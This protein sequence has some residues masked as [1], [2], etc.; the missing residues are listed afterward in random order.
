MPWIADSL[1]FVVI[2]L[3]CCV[4]RFYVHFSWGGLNW[5]LKPRCPKSMNIWFGA[6]YQRGNV[7]YMM[8]SCLSLSMYC[9]S[10]RKPPL[11]CIVLIFYGSSLLLWSLYFVY[12]LQWTTIMWFSYFR[13]K[14][15]LESGHFLSVINI[16]MQL[17]KVSLLILKKLF[18][19]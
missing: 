18:N 3:V 7:I 16:L 14:E 12:F 17:R 9:N 19:Y 8:T 6:A 2:S 11:C 10:K 4:Y 15:T 13:T 5:K 1:S